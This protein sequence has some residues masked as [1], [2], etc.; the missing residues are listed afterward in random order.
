ME[1]KVWVDIKLNIYL[2]HVSLQSVLK[3]INELDE[4][5]LIN[6]ENKDEDKRVVT[7]SLT[8]LG[9]EYYN[10]FVVEYH[11]RI[12]YKLKDISSEQCE[13]AIDIIEKMYKAVKNI[14]KEG[15]ENE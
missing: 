15:L 1:V 12:A 4:K 5:G 13:I 9:E 3:W 2:M 8:D 6:K 11:N 14:E 10:Y 7:L